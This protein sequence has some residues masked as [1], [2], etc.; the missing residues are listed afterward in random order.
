MKEGRTALIKSNNPHLAGG[1]PQGLKCRNGARRGTHDK[2]EPW[3][4]LGITRTPKVC[5][6][7]AFI[8]VILGLG[9]SFH[10]LLGFR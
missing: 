8:A 5:R 6:I 4:G 9:L 10:I 7:M 3:C 2:P 1:E